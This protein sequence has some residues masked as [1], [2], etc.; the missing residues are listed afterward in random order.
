MM[1]NMNR[2]RSLV[3]A[4][5]MRA[6]ASSRD[7]ADLAALRDEFLQHAS[8]EEAL[9]RRTENEA[10]GGGGGGGGGDGSFPPSSFEASASHAAD[11]ARIAGLADVAAALAGSDGR[12]PGASVRGVCRAILEHAA[13]YDALYAGTLAVA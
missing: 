8:R 9:I 10:R 1:N 2:R 11:H 7:A 6:A 3:I 13:T 5:L 4:D 12:V